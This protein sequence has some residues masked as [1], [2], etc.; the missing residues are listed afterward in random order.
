MSDT[1]T[2]SHSELASITGYRRPGDQ[3]A[4]LIR[5]GFSRARR[6][7][8]TGE[9]ILERAHYDAVCAGGLRASAA[10][11]E[12]PKVIPPTLKV[13]NGKARVAPANLR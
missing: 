9:V 11:E 10:A 3:L 1:I 4:E 6:S 8:C 13:I 5:R 7:R 2:L 12:R